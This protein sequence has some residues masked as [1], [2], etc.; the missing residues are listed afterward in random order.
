MIASGCSGLFGPAVDV[1]SYETEDGSIVV[2]TTEQVVKVSAVDE[3]TRTLTLDP[4]WAKSYDVQVSD[5]VE[6]FSQIQVGDELHVELVEALAVSLVPGGAPASVG[7]AA[8]VGLAPVGEKPAM[9]VGASE[10]LTADVVAIDAHS[11][12]L[13]LRFLDGTTQ[14][15]KV[16]KHIDLSK[17]SLRDSVRIRVSEAVMIDF[18]KP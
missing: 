18:R 8:A 15:F 12:R 11:H 4:R 17:V 14:S 1:Q 3:R 9:V 2:E 6:D 7:E 16:A 5:D 13:T 10:E